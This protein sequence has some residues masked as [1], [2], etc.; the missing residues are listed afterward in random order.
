MSWVEDDRACSVRLDIVESAGCDWPRRIAVPVAIVFDLTFLDTAGRTRDPAD[1]LLRLE[2]LLRLRVA[3]L[4][5]HAVLLLNRRRPP[6]PN[7]SITWTDGGLNER[8]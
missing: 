7:T 4:S 2:G 1:D 3:R 8:G 6:T 5:D